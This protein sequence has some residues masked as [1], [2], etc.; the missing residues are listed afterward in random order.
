LAPRFL[1]VEPGNGTVLVGTVIFSGTVEVDPVGPV[2]L[3]ELRVG[4]GDWVQ[5][6]GTVAWSVAV[7]TT[8]YGNGPVTVTFRASDTRSATETT[9]S[10]TV[11]NPFVNARPAVTIATPRPAA[12][13]ETATEIAGTVDD[14]N[15]G[16][17]TVE[18]R[19]SGGAWMAATVT[20]S[21]WSAPLDPTDWPT[22]PVLIEVRA[23]DGTD[24]SDSAFVTVNIERATGGSGGSDLTLAFALV[25]VGAVGALAVLFWRRGRA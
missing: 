20:G 17:L 22:G 13:I 7:N 2:R 9:R 5:A 3:V 25:A 11:D 21:T 1:T 16:T 8:P 24:Y 18:W 12:V 14:A 15:G 23:F 10:Y 6:L 19:H 4:E